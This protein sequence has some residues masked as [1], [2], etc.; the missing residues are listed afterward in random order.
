MTRKEATER[1]QI[2]IWAKESLLDAKD[3]ARA[4]KIK[5]D[6]AALKMAKEALKEEGT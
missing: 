3:G 5:E 1:I 4:R 2:M 6:I